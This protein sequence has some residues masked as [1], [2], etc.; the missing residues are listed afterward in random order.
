MSQNPAFDKLTRL[1]KQLFQLD[2][3]DLD[4]GHYCIM[5][6]RAEEISRFFDHITTSEY[7]RDYAFVLRPEAKDNPMRVHF[8]LTDVAEGEHGNIKA[9]EDQ[10]GRKIPGKSTSSRKTFTD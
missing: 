7:L 8:H 2:Q 6:A 9:G 3:P 1:L 5:H 4:F 10:V